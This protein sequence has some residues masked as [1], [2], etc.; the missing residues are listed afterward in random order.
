MIVFLLNKCLSTYQQWTIL[1]LNW[2][3]CTE[4]QNIGRLNYS[5]VGLRR[6]LVEHNRRINLILVRWNTF[7]LRKEDYFWILSVTKAKLYDMID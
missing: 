3:M 4:I 2:K 6:K 5:F 7:F 1:I